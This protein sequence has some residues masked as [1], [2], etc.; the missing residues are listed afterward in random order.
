MAPMDSGG[1]LPIGTL[2]LFFAVRGKQVVDCHVRWRYQNGLG[3]RERVVAIFPVVVRFAAIKWRCTSLR[4]G[5]AL[6]DQVHRSRLQNY[7]LYGA[8]SNNCEAL[9]IGPP[10]NRQPAVRAMSSVQVRTC[11]AGFCRHCSTSN[12]RI[13]VLKFSRGYLS[14]TSST[15]CGGTWSRPSPSSSSPAPR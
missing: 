10:F 1:S 11:A 3:V 14:S 2:H 15:T 12:L 13:S 9:G 4:P 7:S 6:E 5:A 8:A